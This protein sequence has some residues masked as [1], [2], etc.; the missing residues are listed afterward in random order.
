M[1]EAHPWLYK[2]DIDFLT[3]EEIERINK[4]FDYGVKNGFVDNSFEEELEKSENPD[5]V[6]ADEEPEKAEQTAEPPA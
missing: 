3:E 4:L 5:A 1:S 2:R 6:V